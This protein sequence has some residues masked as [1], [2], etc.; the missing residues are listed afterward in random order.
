M[1]E[2]SVRPARPADVTRLIEIEDAAG[3]RFREIGMDA[4]AD[5]PSPSPDEMFRLVAA[6]VIRV[7]D[8]DGRAA[9]YLQAE[10]VDD[11]AHV[12]QVSVDPAH[13]GLRVGRALLDD[14]TERA[15]AAGLS[16]V[17]LTTYVDVPWNGPYYRRRGFRVL[18]DDE[19]TPGLAALRAE[20]TR[21]GLDRWPRCCMRLDLR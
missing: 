14:N 9:G 7:V 20:E 3:E 21:R 19:I 18:G 13:I 2:H 16:A 12:E 11:C 15:L 17:T 5:D 1:S 8:I 4:V 6:G 10:V